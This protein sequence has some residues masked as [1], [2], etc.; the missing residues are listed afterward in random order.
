[1]VSIFTF[2]AGDV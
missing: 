2:V 1:M